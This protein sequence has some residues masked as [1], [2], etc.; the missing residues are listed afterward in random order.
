MDPAPADVGGS[1]A[2]GHIIA[3]SGLDIVD[4]QVEGRRGPGFRCL[5]RFSDDDVRAASKLQNREFRVF[6][7]GA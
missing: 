5:F 7:N 3:A 1:E 4:H 6:K 2:L